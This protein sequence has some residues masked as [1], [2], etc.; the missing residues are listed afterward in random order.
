VEKYPLLPPQHRLNTL[1]SLVAA[2]EW[3]VLPH[4]AAQL[5]VAV[6]V[7][8]EH[9]HLLG[10]RAGHLTQLQSEVLAQEV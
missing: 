9:R 10:F 4:G 5:A 6:L 7:D 3:V 8:I 1:S 2:V